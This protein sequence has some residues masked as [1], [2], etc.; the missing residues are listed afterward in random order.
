MPTDVG[1]VRAMAINSQNIFCVFGVFTFCNALY[2]NS[3]TKNLFTYFESSDHL[4]WQY[5]DFFM[6]TCLSE[7]VGQ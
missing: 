6:D 2:M 3:K 1:A 7:D 5:I 4:G